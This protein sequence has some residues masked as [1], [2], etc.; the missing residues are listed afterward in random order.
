M[1]V[2]F[3]KIKNSASSISLLSSKAIEYPSLNRAYTLEKIF[4]DLENKVKYD[5][6]VEWIKIQDQIMN[7][8]HIIEPTL[9][10]IFA[11][12]IRQGKIT[13]ESNHFL[14][15]AD[16]LKIIKQIFN[17]CPKFCENFV[18]TNYFSYEL[19]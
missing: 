17:R 9:E 3:Q 14:L 12:D 6:K 13:K 4:F 11:E 10:K 19:L 2:F 8:T 16:I 5:E 1:K 18:K 15:D 7:F